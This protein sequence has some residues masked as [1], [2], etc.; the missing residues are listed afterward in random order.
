MYRDLRGRERS[1]GTFKS[2]R[3]ANRAWQRA[4]SE[5]LAGRIGDPR[6][7]RKTVREYVLPNEAR[8]WITQ[9]HHQLDVNPPTIVKCKVVLDA[10]FTTA[11]NDQVVFIHPG[12]GV[13][14]PPVATQPRR[15]ITAVQ[16][17]RVHDALPDDTMRLLVETSI[18]SGL[19]WGEITELRVRDLDLHS[20]VL[21]VSRTVVELTGRHRPDGVRFIV[22]AYPK[23]KEWRRLGLAPHLVTHL[24]KH[25]HDHKLGMDDLLFAMPVI[26]GPR[27]HVV[28]EA[29]PDPLTL[30]WTEAN[31][32]GHRYRHGTTSAYGPGRCRCRHCK[33]AVASYRAARRAAGKDPSRRPRPPA[34]DPDRHIS[35]G[36]FRNTVWLKAV[37]TA[38][39]G[40]HITPHGLRHAHA[41]WLLAGGADIQVVKERLGHASITTTE[42]Y[43]H[44]M[45]TADQV[46]LDAL[47]PSVAPAGSQPKA[48]ST[49]ATRNFKN[50]AGGRT[51]PVIL[52]LAALAVAEMITR[53]R[54]VDTTR[55][56]RTGQP[57]DAVWIRCAHADAEQLR[58]EQPCRR[59]PGLARFCG[60]GPG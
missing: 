20:G 36:W 39:L 32:R 22:K 34:T 47:T 23:D 44:T 27:R 48:P 28:P 35:R 37:G 11:F 59:R 33:D 31:E 19:R 2:Q 14:T 17:Q 3:E 10:I 16:Y 25:I 45:P 6:R 4:E 41:S 8:E 57:R 13:K 58:V 15:I 26:A 53:N 50:C 7:G 21:T 29:L 46:A 60:R 56:R 30:G 49:I 43:L 55:K 51:V 42:K 1:A 12:K 5:L 52:R 9:L 54:V 24:T 40:F 38:E 18:E